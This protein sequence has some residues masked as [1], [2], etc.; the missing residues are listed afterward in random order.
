MAQ[1]HGVLQHQIGPAIAHEGQRGVVEHLREPALRQ[2][3]PIPAA[4]D[5]LVIRASVLS[6][7][8][9]TADSSAA[10]DG[11]IRGPCRKSPKN[12]KNFRLKTMTSRA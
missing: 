7:N 10:L 3:L 4:L 6:S 1:Q 5:W 2:E 12:A 8:E 11:S 9:R